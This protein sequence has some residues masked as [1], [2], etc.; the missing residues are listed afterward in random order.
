MSKLDPKILWSNAG[1]MTSR[2]DLIS[3][4]KIR[5]HLEFV[6]NNTPNLQ[7]R[8]NTCESI[9]QLLEQKFIKL[10]RD[11]DQSKN[12]IKVPYSN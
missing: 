3:L 9:I 5:Y 8:I 10:K 12:S 7:N 4:Y 2:K 1:S 11:P 6:D